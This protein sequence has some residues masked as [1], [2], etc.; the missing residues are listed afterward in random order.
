MAKQTIN[1]GTNQ[2]D[3]TGDL[4]RTAFQKVNENFTEIYNEVGGESLSNLR[5]SGSTI[6]TDE[7]NTNIIINPNGTGKV[8]IQSDTLLNGDTTTTGSATITG[9][10]AVTGSSTLTG[11]TSIG[12]T[13][14]VTGATTLSS[15]LGVTGN[16]TISGNLI[17]NGNVDLGDA[18]GDTVTFTGRVDS[19]IVPSA[20]GTYDFGGSS[21]R[22]KT[23]YF[24]TVDAT[25]FSFGSS[26]FDQINIS[27]NKIS[28]SVSNANITLD[29]S[30][31]GQ[32]DIRS[33]VT[34]NG[35]TLTG[36]VT[37]NV[38]G[39]I[40]ST[41]T[42]TFSAID[43]NGGAIDGTPIGAASTSTGGFSSISMIDN[44]TINL[45]T[46][47]D[48]R[49]YHT[50]TNSYMDNHV[51][52]LYIRNNVTS[53]L[54][55]NIIIE[56]IA[57]KASAVF[58]DD[59]GVR[60][61]YNN[62]QKFE[63]TISGVEVTGD[64]TTSG[65]FSGDLLTATNGLRIEDNN[66]SSQTTN[67]DIVLIPSGTGKLDI[68]GDTTII[69][70]GYIGSETTPTAI[71]IEADGDVKLSG[72]LVMGNDLYM[73]GKNISSGSTNAD[74]TIDP[75]GTGKV[76]IRSNLS[77]EGK[78]LLPDGDVS[79]NYAGFGAADDLK[80]F[81][82]GT[83]SIVRETGTGGLYLQSDNYVALSKDTDTE[84]MVKGIADGAVELYHN[85]VKKF[86]TSSAGATVTGSLTATSTVDADTFTT[87]G[88]SITDN[89]ITTTRS[90]DE[91]ILNPN[92][93]GNI[94]ADGHVRLTVQ[95][96]NPTAD[97]SS[98]YVFAKTDTNTEVHV[99]DGAGNVTKIS[100]HNEAGDWEY[101]SRNVN[102]GKV[103]RVNMERMIRK[104]EE[105]TG[106]TFI[107]ED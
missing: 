32:V 89:N 40:T 41:G 102:T 94:V 33:N 38:A 70:N 55:N 68:R 95:S 43:V 29:P 86:E 101:Y 107:E 13:L 69:D 59:E 26:T 104:L 54:G 17:A 65:V 66:I 42:S 99:M 84:I 90:N 58:Q 23:G 100:P 39:N 76:N 88:I 63:T 73:N 97:T 60:L 46:G 37:G 35:N 64:I 53:D 6:T 14:S 57:G 93:T 7:T 12:G 15:T 30:G 81:H 105:L 98:G 34:L 85:N 47:N 72:S 20:G 79:N 31:T 22:W 106:E 67:T 5:F 80:I 21:Q 56:A 103:M 77:V 24:D 61:Y 92:G 44:A 2:D 28:S 10:I 9:N 45:G 36:D 74:V 11:N 27:G 75:S 3:G 52:P 96:G 87:D 16:T 71:Q 25:T 18:S 49:L 82:N 4:L 19:S 48:L 1:I 51:G 62:A 83:H 91:L 50:G 8:D 78:L